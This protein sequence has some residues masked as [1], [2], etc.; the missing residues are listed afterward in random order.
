MHVHSRPLAGTRPNCTKQHHAA[1]LLCSTVNPPASLNWLDWLSVPPVPA[2]EL[3]LTGFFVLC[4]VLPAV[5]VR[6]RTCCVDDLQTCLEGYVHIDNTG[7]A[8]NT[9]VGD[10]FHHLV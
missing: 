6:G 3:R 2:F 4:A 1:P 7:E 10:C 8:A 9:Y 5:A